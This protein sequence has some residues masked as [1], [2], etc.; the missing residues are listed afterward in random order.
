VRRAAPKRARISAADVEDRAEEF[1][2]AKREVAAVYAK[3]TPPPPFDVTGWRCP[4]GCVPKPMWDTELQQYRRIHHHSCAWW[5]S[6]EGID[7]TPF[8]DDLSWAEPMI[9][10]LY[11]SDQRRQRAERGER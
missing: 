4:W 2:E 7:H 5:Q 6:G 11:E 9:T 1:E 8:D 3:F 10:A